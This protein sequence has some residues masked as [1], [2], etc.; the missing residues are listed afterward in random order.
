MKLL[1][2]SLAALYALLAACMFFDDLIMLIL[3][4]ER[5]ERLLGGAW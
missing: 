3:Y 1:A 4:S 2:Y 5:V